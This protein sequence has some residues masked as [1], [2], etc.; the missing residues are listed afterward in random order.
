[1]ANKSSFTP[2]EWSRLVAS[3]VVASMAITAADPG[4]LWS[5]LQESMSSG[6]ALL[7]AKQDA[8]ATP[9]VKAVADDIANTETRNAV[10]DSFQSQ[11]KGSQFADVK[12]KAIEELHGVSVLLDA[13]A[14]DEAAA[15][16]SWLWSVARKSAEA[17]KEGGFLGF[18]GVAVSDAEKATLSDIAAAL[19]NPA[20]SGAG[21]AET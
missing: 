1:M 21:L 9:L 10:R 20:G 18:G 16:K 2:E 12:R 3:P 8:Q 14:P 17:G 4:G 6:W 15:F 5:L 7:E 13:K 19:G 11:F